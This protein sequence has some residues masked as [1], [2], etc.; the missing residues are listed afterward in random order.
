MKTTQRLI[1]TTLAVSLL[2]LL[3]TS[4]KADPLTLTLTN[5]NQSGTVGSILTFGGSV[6]NVTAPSVQIVSSQITFNDGA[7]TL[8]LDDSPFV[9]N[10]LFQTVGP[11]TTL[12]PLDMFT[13]E[14]LAG[15]TAGTYAGVLSVL[16]N[17]GTNVLE[18]N[19]F[20]FSVRVQPSNAPVPEPMTML[21]LGTG[22]AG[23]A[24][25]VRRRRRQMP[26]GPML[27]RAGR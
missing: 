9:T 3:S 18:T 8:F 26:E 13:V 14:M 25:I 27:R 15:A 12:G 4:A 2:A 21:L 11:G 22:L 23:L 5:P 24:G 10:F 17:N 6:L 7:G 20:S 16:S 19:P 1:I